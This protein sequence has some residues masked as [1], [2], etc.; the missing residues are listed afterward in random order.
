MIIVFLITWGACILI[1]EKVVAAWEGVYEKK[2]P[3]QNNWNKK[4]VLNPFLVVANSRNTLKYA[5]TLF[6][7]LNSSN[8]IS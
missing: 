1:V 3:K 4:R 5:E 6:P 7:L 8:Y 2:N